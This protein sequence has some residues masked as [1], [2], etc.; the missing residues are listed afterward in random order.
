[1]I[2]T[3]TETTAHNY[4]P[5]I[6]EIKEQLNRIERCTVLAA[7]NVL[8]IEDVAILTGFSKSHIYTL[9]SKNEIPHYKPNGRT[10]FFDRSELEAWLK[11]NRVAPEYEINER[12]TAYN[13]AH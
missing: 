4:T 12:A 11:R 13:V 5:M 8:N 6:E 1:M 3:R 2:L 10:V 7:K 9:T